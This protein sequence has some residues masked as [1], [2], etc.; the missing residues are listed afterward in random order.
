MDDF[1]KK[2]TKLTDEDEDDEE[3]E[4]DFEQEEETPK[5]QKQETKETPKK[6]DD[7]E[8]KQIQ[9]TISSLHDNGVFRLELLNN[10]Q[11]INNN[12]RVIAGVLLEISGYGKQ[13]K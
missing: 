11:Q 6:V 2:E 12:M 7:A 1:V 3:L 10:L 9:D 8:I 4:E 5:V 13:T